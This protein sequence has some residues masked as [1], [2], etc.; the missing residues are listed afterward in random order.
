MGTVKKN[1][2]NNKS[3]NNTQNAQGHLGRYEDEVRQ[4]LAHDNEVKDSDY[5]LMFRVIF[6]RGIDPDKLSA[7]E[8]LRM[9]AAKS[10]VGTLPSMQSISRLRRGLQ[11]RDPSL[12]GKR[13]ME[14]H[15]RASE[16]KDEMSIS[17]GQQ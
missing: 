10:N 12:R 16:I 8:M 5:A 14:R 17:N 2:S 6:N 15:G 3:N 11:Q 13:Y 1:K 4:A 9:M 7:G